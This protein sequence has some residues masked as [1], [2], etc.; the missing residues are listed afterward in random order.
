ML[1][2]FAASFALASALLVGITP[3][4]QAQPAEDLGTSPASSDS[5]SALGFF[6]PASLPADIPHHSPVH[7]APVIQDSAPQTTALTTNPAVEPHEIMAHYG[8]VQ[9]LKGDQLSVRLLDGTARTYTVATTNHSMTFRRGSL[10]G[11]D[12]TGNNY[13]TNIAPPRVRRIFEGTVIVVEEDK[14]GL[15]S[16]TGEQLVTSLSPEKIAYM[17]LVPGSPLRVTQY[18]NTWATKVC[19]PTG[20]EAATLLSKSSLKRW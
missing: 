14:L 12:T 11:F 13:I 19:S 3:L 18:E 10:I 15:V 8:L 1:V 20:E 17:K 4:S 6:T 16:A 7:A 5:A 9:S 2:K